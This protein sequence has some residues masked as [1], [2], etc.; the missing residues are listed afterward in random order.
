MALPTTEQR[1]ARIDALSTENVELMD[2]HCMDCPATCACGTR[3][4]VWLQIENNKTSIT[5]QEQA[6]ERGAV[7]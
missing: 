6:I 3:C 5:Y 2:K 1:E 7:A 4:L